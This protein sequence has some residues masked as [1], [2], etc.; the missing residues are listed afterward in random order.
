[1]T[2][3][4]DIWSLGCVFSEAAIWIADGYD[5]LTDY[6][7]QRRFE[8]EITPLR[9][10]DCFHDGEQ[11]LQSV[12]DMHG[13]IESR[14]RK[15]DYITK[16]VLDSMADE[17]LWEEDRPTAK[18]LWRKAD[19][20]L[21]RA[22]EKL[23]S[24]V[25]SPRPGSRQRRYSAPRLQPPS[26]PLPAIPGKAPPGLASVLEKE[27]LN[28]ETWRSQLP[29][30]PGRS[31]GGGTDEPS[32]TTSSSNLDRELNG[33]IASW[34]RGET[35]SPG[36]PVTPFSSPRVS[37][38][39]EN[40]KHLP[41]EGRPRALRI[42]GSYEHPRPKNPVSRGLSFDSKNEANEGF[43]PVSEARTMEEMRNRAR[44][45][46][47]ASSGSHS[48]Q[49][50]GHSIPLVSASP[51]VS[52]FPSYI[53][54]KSQRRG[55]GFVLFPPHSPYHSPREPDEIH[56][57]LRPQQTQTSDSGSAD[58]I[59]RSVP[60]SV[61][62]DTSVNLQPESEPDPSGMDYLSLNTCLEWK[63]AQKKAKKEAQ[64]IRLPGAHLI[65]PLR[66]RDHVLPLFS[67][68]MTILTSQPAIHSR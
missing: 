52:S 17:M 66:N 2:W 35:N 57:A 5:G 25:E 34:Q 29:G 68:L 46:S 41:N 56:P 60:S 20:I 16:D 14:L 28:V 55:A 62:S 58:A 54:P 40:Q 12:L 48:P 37:V 4:G 65:E 63:H 6:R 43:P 13:D 19:V 50:S 23:A 30:S 67:L 10:G 44:A 59:P 3:A 27:P 42:H 24:T 21:G 8:M 22:R 15:S 26:S 61:F 47:R 18:A 9:N 45:A 31:H 53:P 33:S 1:M 39:A 64:N 51:V 38:F 11:V 32:S 36:S 49:S 7:D